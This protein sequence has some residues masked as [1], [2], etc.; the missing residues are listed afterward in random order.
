MKH[1]NWSLNTGSTV[2]SIHVESA[3]YNSESRVAVP[4]NTANSMFSGLVGN[5]QLNYVFHTLG[6]IISV[7]C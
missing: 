1:K 7:L 4:F 6:L 2:C 5:K 3:L